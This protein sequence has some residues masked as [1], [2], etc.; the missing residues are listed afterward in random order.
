MRH[1]AREETYDARVC[2]ILHVDDVARVKRLAAVGLKRFRY[3]DDEILQQ[4][5]ARRIGI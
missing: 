5:V 4:R 3:P 2:R 1:R